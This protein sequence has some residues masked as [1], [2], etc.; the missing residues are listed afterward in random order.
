MKVPARSAAAMTSS[1]F[2]AVV[3]RPSREKVTASSSV[4]GGAGV[5]AERPV[6]VPGCGARSLIGAPAVLDVNEE[7]V[8]EHVD[9]RVDR[10]GDRR[11]EHADGR[12]L[13]W[14]GEPRRD[15]VGD[16]EEEVEV[17]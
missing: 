6:P 13:R 5:S 11:A 3:G 12:L 8:A 1:P 17:L 10:G 4:N 16:V 14:P 9:G 7:L 15:V 2:R